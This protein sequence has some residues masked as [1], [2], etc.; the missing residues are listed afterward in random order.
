MP[1]KQPLFQNNILVIM[2]INQ[3]DLSVQYIIVC[4]TFR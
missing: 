3:Y 4:V 1:K 2:F